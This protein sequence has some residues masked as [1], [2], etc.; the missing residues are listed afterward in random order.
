MASPPAADYHLCAGPYLDVTVILCTIR[1]W[2][3]DGARVQ[4]G[5]AAAMSAFKAMVPCGSWIK[6]AGSCIVTT[7]IR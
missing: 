2:L 3:P 7:A 4:Y 1:A 5:D 6:I